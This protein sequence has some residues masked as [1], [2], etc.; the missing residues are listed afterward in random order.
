VR[1]NGVTVAVAGQEGDRAAADLAEGD[2]ARRVA[3]RCADDPAVLLS[4]GSRRMPFTIPTGSTIANFPVGRAAL[5]TGT[6]AGL[7]TM[8]STVSLNGADVTPTPAPVSTVRIEA[9][10]PVI[11][12]LDAVRT[13]AGFEL[14]IYGFATSRQ[15]TQ[16]RVTLTAASGFTLA[17][18]QFTVDLATL[19]ASY[20]GSPASV[21]FGSQFKVVLPFALSDPLGVASVSVTLV[22]ALGSSAPAS[23][24][25]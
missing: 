10:P 11:T 22:N 8:R 13:S 23:A 19:F 14:S 18:T 3:V 21:P 9:A 15:V 1:R 20:Y 12:R 24:T 7:A 2:R 16:A 25:F 17:G 5:Q 6:V 4:N